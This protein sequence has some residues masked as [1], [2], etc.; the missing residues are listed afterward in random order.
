MRSPHGSYVR[1]RELPGAASYHALV[2]ICDVAGAKYARVASD[3]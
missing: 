2:S 1:A 3:G